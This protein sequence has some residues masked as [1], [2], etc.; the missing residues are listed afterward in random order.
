MILLPLPLPCWESWDY[1][2]ESFYGH[3]YDATLKV[4]LGS[5]F[6]FTRPALCRTEQQPSL[7][8]CCETGWMPLC[9]TGWSWTWNSSSSASQ[10]L[11]L[12][13]RN[14]MCGLLLWLLTGIFFLPFFLTLYY[15]FIEEYVADV[16]WMYMLAWRV[17]GVLMHICALARGDQRSEVGIFLCCLLPTLLRPGLS[18]NLKLTDLARLAG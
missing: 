9:I 14:T 13:A 8:C 1:R 4:V 5:S 12:Q 18:L 17:G 16:C 2:H 11:R 10:V 7:C 15:L 6:L 3:F